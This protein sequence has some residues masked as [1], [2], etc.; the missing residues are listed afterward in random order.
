MTTAWRWPKV[1]DIFCNE[2]YHDGAEEKVGA[3]VGYP[4]DDGLE[5][6]IADEGDNVEV[7]VPMSNPD[8]GHQV[9]ATEGRS[10][11]TCSCGMDVTVGARLSSTYAALRAE[12]G[13]P[14]DGPA[15][16][17]RHRSRQ[18]LHAM[19]DTPDGV[20]RLSLA[21]LAHIVSS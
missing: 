7:R 17:R 14:P 8:S 1:I 13:Y 6:W 20:S 9:P 2:P 15:R 18:A 5:D 4:A 3:L 21:R 16:A 10:K 12:R 11:I 19:V